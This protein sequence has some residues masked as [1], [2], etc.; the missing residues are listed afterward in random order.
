MVPLKFPY[1]WSKH[2]P[3]RDIS[4]VYMEWITI[5]VRNPIGDQS[6]HKIFVIFHCVDLDEKSSMTEDV[7][8]GTLI[9]NFTT[10]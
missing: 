8:L 6:K 4:R 9:S 5:S 7:V 10:K 3:W 2:D 1:E